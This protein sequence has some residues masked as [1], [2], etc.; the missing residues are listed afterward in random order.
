MTPTRETLVR[1]L[2]THAYQEGHFELA[3][4]RTASFYLDAKQ[5]TYRAEA[6]A[7]VGKAVMDLIRPYAVQAVGGMTLGAD[8]IVAST[9]IASGDTD[10]PVDGFIV[11]KNPKG[12]GLQ[13]SI[14]GVSPAGRRVAMVED[15]VT[16]GGSALK[17]AR[18]VQDAGAEVVVAVTL[19]DREQGGTE[20]FAQAG[21]PLLAVTTISQIREAL[22]RI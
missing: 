16:T 8:A 18:I 9:V 22:T 12:H 10:S 3:S 2:A 6:A 21:I 1:L 15:V 17:A 11:R 4:G 5:V 20:A 13:Q 7:L 19:I 14:E